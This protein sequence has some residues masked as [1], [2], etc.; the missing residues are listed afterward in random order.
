M[1]ESSSEFHVS[2]CLCVCSEAV[3]GILRYVRFTGEL[4]KNPK[5]WAAPQIN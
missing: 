3:F 5:V 4:A 2:V 1:L